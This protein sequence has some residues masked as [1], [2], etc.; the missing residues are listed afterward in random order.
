MDT[1]AHTL[2]DPQTDAYNPKE[3]EAQW[4]A[5]W[6]AQACF[7]ALP[8]GET[9]KPKY[10]VLEMF[11]YPSGRIHMGHVRNYTMGDV[12]AR[13]KL[14]QGYN[15][16][17]PMGWD[18]FGMPAENAAIEKNI[19]PAKWTQDNIAAMRAQLK[20]LGLSIDWSRELATCDPAYY[21]TEQAMFLDF[22][23][24]GLAERREALVNWDPIDKTVLANEQVIDGK[25]WRSGA[26]VEQKKLT[27]WF[28]R[29]TDYAEDL[30]TSLDDLKDWPDKVRLM[31]KNWIGKSS[32]LHCRFDLTEPIRGENDNLIE[33]IDIFT[34]RADTL[35]GA[36]F[37][38]IAAEHPLAKA[39]AKDKN[40]P[41]DKFLADC[42]ALGTSE[43]AIEK[44]DKLG[45]DT[46]LFVRH[47]LDKDWHLPVYI[48][49]F[50]LMGYGTGAIFACPAHDQRDLDF[51]RKYDLPVLP[52]VRPKECGDD[53][54]IEN[55]AYTSS[56]GETGNSDILFNARDLNG[57]TPAKARTK[58]HKWFESEGCGHT[59]TLYRLRD[60]GISRQRYWGCPIP[61]IHCDECG[62]V[63]VP[64]ED[65][66]VILPDDISFT[67]KDQQ[68]GNPLDHHPTWKY[69]ACP[70]CGKEA[71]R[72]TDTFDTFIDSSWYYAR[73]A[74]GADDQGEQS[75]WLPIDQYIGGV[76]HA[77]LHLLYSRFFARAMHKTHH[78]DL[79]EPF[80][81]LFTQGMVCHE[82][83]RD[84]KG[85]WVSP[86]E[87]QKQ[88]AKQS[89]KMVLIADPTQV[90]KVG[91]SEKMSKSKRNTIDPDDI[92]TR[93]GA[94]T[95]RWFM[96]SDSPPERDVQWTQEGVEGAWRFVQRLWRLMKTASANYSRP[97]TQ[98]APPQNVASLMTY[99]LSAD[100][101]EQARTLYRLAHTAI[102]DI[103]A[104]LEALAFNRA[105]ARVHSLTNALVD[106]KPQNEE[107]TILHY[108][109][110]LWLTRLFAPMMPHLAE[111]CW[112]V[113]GGEGLVVEAAWLSGDTK[114]LEAAEIMLPVQINGKK[115]TEIC[116]AADADNAII[117]AQVLQDKK[118]EALL[119]G[120]TPKKIIIVS[121]RIINLVV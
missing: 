45:F 56:G 12:V 9:D 42:A 121:G 72:E 41:L 66:P 1:S 25:G 112:Q 10:Y 103:T 101:S 98:N 78:L 97:A 35:Y 91:A 88:D 109:A 65:L 63:G 70:Q 55:T 43:T 46:K 90:I 114:A 38:A 99:R 69:V 47:P 87:V 61:I 85:G 49:N 31:Q 33:G 30:L 50:V 39:L 62:T 4:Q 57:L 83:Y 17:H 36:S 93:Y 32:G 118:V 111:S 27:Q 59:Q 102:I 95:A 117:E 51:A 110:C 15:V 115:R 58:L 73:F 18:A 80:R 5:Q 107:D 67:P 75:Y 76:E 60:W 84:S 92:I 68:A 23:A 119:N 20:R 3:S 22:W 86:Q 28:L 29:I 108:A 26:L 40:K 44:A 19:H 105:V 79:V 16:L 6:A 116:V 89:G 13:F 120:Q 82:T 100:A 2:Y 106:F 11:P 54:T 104:D 96:L 94:D 74:S 71:R 113:L 24:A 77:I 8:R 53:F 64:R 52:V 81:G 7:T 48:A 21:G 14:A 34:T 37:C